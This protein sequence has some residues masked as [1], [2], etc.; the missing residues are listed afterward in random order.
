VP[1]LNQPKFSNKSKNFILAFAFIKRLEGGYVNCPGDRGGATNVGITQATYDAFRK[2]HYLPT[3][4]V[5]NIELAEIEE[6]Y[7]A[8]YWYPICGDKFHPAISFVLFDCAVHSGPG[9]A[10]LY[11]QR[12]LRIQQTGVF[13]EPT[14][15][16]IQNANA[17]EFV[18]A[19]IAYRSEMLFILSK[20][21]SQRKFRRGWLARMH[22]VKEF[23][24]EF[25]NDAA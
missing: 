6:I 1:T 22:L 13:D 25:F 4:F 9:R 20:R 8:F 15:A 2:A 14:I 19:F 11:A 3:V 18:K 12:I 16:A 7:Y 10:A 21:P 23:S 5:G 17:D 24:K